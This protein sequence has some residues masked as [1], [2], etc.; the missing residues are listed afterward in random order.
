MVRPSVQV[1]AD[2][3]YGD[4]GVRRS[5]SVAVLMMRC[6]EQATVRSGLIDFVFIFKM[7]FVAVF[8]FPGSI[9]G[10]VTVCQMKRSLMKEVSQRLDVLTFFVFHHGLL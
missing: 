2:R 8:W 10:F 1:G 5:L 3:S 6:M 4:G 9:F 7:C